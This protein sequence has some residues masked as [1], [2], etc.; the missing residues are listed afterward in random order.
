MNYYKILGIKKGSSKEE[1]RRAYLKLALL[2]HPD[3][4]IDNKDIYTEKFQKIS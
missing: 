2:N 3:R 4:H 1:I